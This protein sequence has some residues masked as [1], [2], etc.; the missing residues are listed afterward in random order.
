MGSPCI[1]VNSCYKNYRTTI[2]PLL[3]SL[4]RAGVDCRQVHVVIGESVEE[5]DQL[6]EVNVHFRR[7]ANMDDNGLNWLVE[8]EART[9]VPDSAFV[10]YMHDTC[11][12]GVT[13]RAHL[14]SW[15]EQVRRTQLVV[16]QLRPLP[17]MGMGW[18][19][20]GWLRSPE[21]ASYLTERVNYD[22]SP[23]AVQQVKQSVEDAVFRIAHFQ[24]RAGVINQLPMI[25]ERDA[26][27]YGTTTARIV[28]HFEIMDVYKYKSNF[29]Q[30]DVAHLT[31]DL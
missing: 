18:Y 21:V 7:W 2:P 19:Q 25:I 23:T 6:D 26:R 17:S 16:L 24:G 15:A 13:F 20:A 27:P 22:T 14:E 31:I 12:V 4:K 1:V 11:T 10:F 29:G 5:K 28:E 3:G 30:T 9:H 8:D